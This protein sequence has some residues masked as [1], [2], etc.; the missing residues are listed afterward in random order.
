MV[1]YLTK[2]LT[3][4]VQE[5]GAQFKGHYQLELLENLG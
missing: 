4:I 5:G 3:L 1:K 2:H